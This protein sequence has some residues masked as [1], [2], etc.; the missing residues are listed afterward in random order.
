MLPGQIA[1]IHPSVVITVSRV[2][3]AVC[4]VSAGAQYS[5]RAMRCARMA[6]EATTRRVLACQ[7]PGI[8]S[9]VVIT[10]CRVCSA[11]CSGAVACESAASRTVSRQATSSRVLAR[12]VASIDFAVVVAVGRIR[13]TSSRASPGVVTDSASGAMSSGV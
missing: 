8:D 4:A 7:I 5:S 10:V 1:S 9:T 11:M 2:H 13:S 12:Y 6:C 3:G